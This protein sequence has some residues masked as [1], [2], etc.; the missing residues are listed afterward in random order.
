MNQKDVLSLIEAFRDAEIERMHLKDGEFSLKLERSPRLLASIAPQSGATH[1]GL[2]SATMIS[3]Q[4]ASNAHGP[5]LMDGASSAHVA[6]SAQVAPSAQDGSPVEVGH[7][8]ETKS[9][10]TL[11]KA[12][13]VGVYYHAPSPE[14]DP[15]VREEQHVEKG[16]TL[17]VIEAMKMMNEV[18]APLSGTV[19]AIFGKNGAL[20]E[21]DQVL[22]T[23]RPDVS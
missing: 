23:I 8:S 18:Q 20:V 12:P 19:T 21:F 10:D 11:V 7:E 4:G 2:E 22:F 9:T 6:S 16:D 3:A 17:C 5:S 15:F 1:T 13:L 14:A